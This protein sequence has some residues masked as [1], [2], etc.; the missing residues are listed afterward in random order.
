MNIDS[1]PYAVNTQ[2]NIFEF[3][4]DS[5]GP[6]GI[7][8]KRINYSLKSSLVSTYFHLEFGDWYE[9]TKFLDDLARSNNSDT[10]KILGTIVETILE[11]LYKHPD[12]PIFAK[13]STPSRTRLYQIGIA[14]KL[15]DIRGLLSVYGFKNG[16]WELFERSRDYT[17][18]KVQLYEK[19]KWK[20]N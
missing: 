1:Y 14:G 7:V 17:A 13:G 11:V 20:E 8:K 19:D 16:Q 5:I 3:T 2:R 9:E 4:F 18:F 12:I 15:A 10:N 6:K